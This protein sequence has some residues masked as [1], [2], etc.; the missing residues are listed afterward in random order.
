[1]RQ[2]KEV[3]KS[4]FEMEKKKGKNRAEESD[5]KV[6][7]RKEK[8]NKNMKVKKIDRKTDREMEKE[9]KKRRVAQG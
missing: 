6:D 7:R 5:T 4:F 2:G 3:D 8:E 9:R 1:M